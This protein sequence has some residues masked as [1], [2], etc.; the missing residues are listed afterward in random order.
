[1][2]RLLAP[3]LTTL[4]L[5]LGIRGAIYAQPDKIYF[6]NFSG[7]RGLPK[8]GVNCILQDQ[9]GFL[10]VGTY[11][12]LYRFDGHTATVF[13]H[14]PNNAE[15]SLPSNLILA[16][17]EDATG[18]LWVGTPVGLLLV[19]K[20]T[21]NAFT[22]RPDSTTTLDWVIV[23]SILED[24]QGI[25]WLG[26]ERGIS[27]FD[28]T[29]L[30][31]SRY[32]SP[33][34]QS[35]RHLR[36]DSLGNLW[37]ISHQGLCRFYPP[38]GKFDF[39]TLN[40]QK[41][42]P[43]MAWSLSIDKSGIAWI[44]TLG[45]GLF[46]MDTKRP[47]EFVASHPHR[48]SK[49]IHE[50]YSTER[51]V[52]IASEGL[53]RIDPVNN[54]VIDYRSK[55][56]Q[57]GTLSN[58]AISSLYQ[59]RSMN[60]WVGTSNGLSKAAIRTSPF[61]THQMTRTPVSFMRQ[62][63]VIN[64]ILE[65]RTGALWVGSDKDGLLRFDP[66]TR[67]MESIIVNP[68][69][70]RSSLEGQEWPLVEDNNGRLWVGTDLDKGLYVRNSPTEPFI[71]HDSEISVR[72]LALAPSGTL[73]VASDVEGI[74][75]FD[76]GTKK[77]TYYRTS[78]ANGIPRGTFVTA[79]LVSRSGEVWITTL[80]QGVIRLNPINGK[81]TFYKPNINS[82]T[83]YIN[84][85]L[86]LYEDQKGMIWIG[87]A[88]GGLSRLDPV[89]EIFSSFTT[90]QGLPSNLISSVIG[91]DQGNLWLG[92]SQGLSRF[93]PNTQSCRNFTEGDGLPDNYFRTGCAYYRKG[94]LFFGTRN[95]LVIFNPD[96]IKEVSPSLPVYITSLKVNEKP[97]ILLAPQIELPYHK[98]FLTFDF[99]SIN[100]DAPEKTRYTYQLIGL[101]P[102][103]V[104][105]GE[106]RFARYTDLRPGTYKFRVKASAD[107]H[108]WNEESSIEV[109]IHPPW[110]K[111]WWAY[112]LYCVMG[113][114]FLFGLIHYS[115]S[116]ERLQSDLK[117]QR[118]EADKMHEIDHLKSQFF[119]NISHEFRTPVTLILGPLEK[120]LSRVSPGS[121]EKAVYQ[122]MQ[123]NAR[124]LLHLINQ[125]LDLSKLETGKMQLETKPTSIVGFLKPIVLS[126]TSLAERKNIQ[127]QFKFPTGD[128]VLYF[129]VDK[130]EKI[131]TNL[132][133]N[134][135]KFTPNDGKITI[136]AGL[137]KADDKVSS[138]DLTTNDIVR[139]LEIKVH[140]NGQGIPTDQQ[141]K[142]FD[143]FYQADVHVREYDGSGIGLALV[144][145][146]VALHGGN[147]TVESQHG[148]GACFTVRLP[149]KIADYEELQI[150]EPA[151]ATE[152]N[153]GADKINDVTYESSN[154]P[155]TVTEDAPLILIV[156]D[157]RDIR[158]FISETLCSAYKIA[159]AGDGLEGYRLAIE[160]VPDLILSDL[161][162]PKMDGIELCRRLKHEKK[163]DHI[164]IIMLTAKASGESRIE[165]LQTGAD[166]YI[167]KPFE[168]AELLIRI[169]N[170]IDG[171]NK[172]RER[173]S[174]EITLQPSSIS[175]TSMDAQLLTHVMKIV[176]DHMADSNFGVELFCKE[177]AM[178][179]MQL[180]RKLKALTDQAPGDFIRIMRLKRAA[181]LITNNAGNIAD[182]AYL[183][184]FND[185]SYFT[186]CFQKQF[187]KTPSEFATTK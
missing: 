111:T 63:N 160:I 54:E 47:G 157:N 97:V 165:G 98:N 87:T 122:T 80:G 104:S 164:P 153:N 4:V 100:Y 99:A 159:E 66:K 168:A 140:D 96:S 136:A 67:L 32:V 142:I 59:D 123:R 119:A 172:M 76:P 166:D 110:W 45:D 156:E 29:T 35:F 73:W 36:R 135:F 187:G 112:G 79:L 178:S 145:E 81:F 126:F 113:I 161:M 51:Y 91:D 27:R 182:V 133:S 33:S 44:G 144:K 109:I 11:E 173:F 114:I 125:L 137:L 23:R 50:V 179:R 12:G 75:S 186:K 150:V 78:D 68:S 117:L 77:F 38:T 124:R 146:L 8:N 83:G 93:N 90:R 65:D 101:D 120:F 170:L 24:P 181:E 129:D 42:E 3:W 121:E 143:R 185:P 148:E 171:R 62:E 105:S 1:M 167:V 177:A 131:V 46:Q 72:L 64:N 7:W 56:F 132:L 30:Q 151:M 70:S 15:Q 183:V 134:A 57:P 58:N 43:A 163:T 92:T 108:I 41:R 85:A 162:M 176:E 53:Q 184:G 127:Y 82:Q 154:H 174:R 118:M 106:L 103:W 14:D 2:K 17:H 107:N 84:V 5:F 74:A 152:Q 40:T 37:A 9:E 94:K 138:E 10:W 71:R 13:Q 22:Y 55:D 158:N 16:L 169:K 60:L 180:H 102:D 26:T 175:I 20:R 31:F 89:N 18:R 52:W 49:T 48:I 116:R 34:G 128:P 39:F 141:D 115:V 69:D 130:L 86:S 19:D 155:N 6:E 28:P 149:L 21:G 25:L 147:I 139:I 88:E 61:Y 95:G